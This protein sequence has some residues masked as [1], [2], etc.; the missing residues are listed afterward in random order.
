MKF[1]DDY[2]Y[3]GKEL[4]CNIGVDPVHVGSNEFDIFLF[5][6][7]KFESNLKAE[8]ENKE[9]ECQQLRIGK[10]TLKL[11]GISIALIHQWKG[12][13][14]GFGIGKGKKIHPTKESGGRDVKGMCNIGAGF[15]LFKREKT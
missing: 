1:I 13:L 2:F 5:F 8:T 9:E 7:E 11:I 6:T 12:F 10:N 14:E 4:S 15:S 3:I